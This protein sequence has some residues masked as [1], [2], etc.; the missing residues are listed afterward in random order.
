LEYKEFLEDGGR[1]QLAKEI[2]SFANCEGDG[3][4]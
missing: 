2:A 4:D 3:I 1:T